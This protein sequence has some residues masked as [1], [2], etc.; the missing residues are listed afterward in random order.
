[1]YYTSFQ[2][3]YV[4]ALES[5]YCF[6]V[7]QSLYRSSQVCF[8][9]MWRLWSILELRIKETHSCSQTSQ[10]R[11][12]DRVSINKHLLSSIDS[13]ARRRVN[14]FKV[15]LS[16]KFH[17]ITRLPLTNFYLIFMCFAIVLGNTHFLIFYYSQQTVLFSGFGEM[18]ENSFKACLGTH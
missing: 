2:P 10:S 4:V 11:H 16:P 13:D 14:L 7:F 15:D 6:E 17:I 9:A 18:I 3:W 1:M 5:I 8:G 12:A